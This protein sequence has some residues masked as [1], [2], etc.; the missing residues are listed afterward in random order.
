MD[1]ETGEK[2]ETA[3]KI[4]SWSMLALMAANGGLNTM[5]DELDYSALMDAVEGP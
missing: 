5:W 4:V 2:Y 3:G 1:V